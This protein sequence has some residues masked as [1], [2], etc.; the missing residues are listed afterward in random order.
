[1][2][3]PMLRL[4]Q[5]RPPHADASEI[6]SDE[7]RS[8]ILPRIPNEQDQL[9]NLLKEILTCKEHAKVLYSALIH[10]TSSDFQLDLVVKVS[11]PPWIS[12]NVTDVSMLQEFYAICVRD[13]ESLVSQLGWANAQAERAKKD[14]ARIPPS[15]N[16]PSF[17]NRLQ[18]LHSSES[19][20]SLAEEVFVKLLAAN[21][22]L[23]QVSFGTVRKRF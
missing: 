16:S 18:I 4:R 9:A 1:M 14:R 2:T 6:G 15:S 23:S 10:A 20:R 21:D 13:Q 11:S 22:E 3:D 19:E 5:R 8:A 7:D 12:E 17:E